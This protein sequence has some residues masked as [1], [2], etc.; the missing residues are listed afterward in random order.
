MDFY[1]DKLEV[2]EENFYIKKLTDRPL[3]IPY[4]KDV[5]GYSRD[6]CFDGGIGTIS[7]VSHNVYFSDGAKELEKAGYIVRLKGDLQTVKKPVYIE[8]KVI[9]VSNQME[10]QSKSLDKPIPEESKEIGGTYIEDD[11]ADLDSPFV[12]EDAFYKDVERNLKLH[13]KCY[14]N[15]FDSSDIFK[16][17]K[18]AYLNYNLNHDIIKDDRYNAEKAAASFAA[19]LA[20]FKLI[21]MGRQKQISLPEEESAY[22]IMLYKYDDMACDWEDYFEQ[23]GKELTDKGISSK[24]SNRDNVNDDEGEEIDFTPSDFDEYFNKE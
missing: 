19:K 20:Y 8:R 14:Y 6:A 24:H 2:E 11:S 13:L 9:V 17:I 16:M 21:R 3:V 4:N 1:K 7:M 12:L 23:E 15:Y 18:A 10:T 5:W 22:C